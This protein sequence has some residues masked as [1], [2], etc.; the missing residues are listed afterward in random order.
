MSR[1]FESSICEISHS[2]KCISLFNQV[3]FLNPVCSITAALDMTPRT[4]IFD[5]KKMS[6]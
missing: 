5:L 1:K 2:I 6:I 4:F 3:E